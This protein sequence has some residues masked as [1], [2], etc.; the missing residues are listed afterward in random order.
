MKRKIFSLGRGFLSVAIVTGFL[1]GGL[2]DVKAAQPGPSFQGR[3]ITFVVPFTAGGGSDI[4][5]RMIARHLGQYL[6]GKP[7]IVI[8]NMP[9]AG[10]LIGGNHA[11]SSKANGLTC[12]ISSGG[13]ITA[14]IIRPKGIEYRLE[15]MY[16]LCSSPSGL[17]YYGKPNLIKEPKDIF[18]AKGLIFGHMPATGGTSSGFIWAKELLGFQTE[19]MI[20]A[21]GGSGDS[22][23][24]FLQGETNLCGESVSGYTT[25]MKSY[26]EKGQAVPI[27]QTGILDENGNV[28]RDPGA[29]DVLTAVEL[30]EQVH[31]KK[32]SGPDWKVYR[33]VVGGRTFDNSLLL[34]PKIPKDIVDLYGEAIPKMLKDSKFIAEAD[35]ITP[36][37]PYS[38]GKTLVKIFQE[39]VAAPP[40]VAEYMKR[41]LKEKYQVVLE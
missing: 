22:R 2:A 41:V 33:L 39:G 19:K 1:L 37:A 18:T 26:V 20:L 13:L 6:P 10:N 31:G 11:W 28:M 8:R 35:K 4:W 38:Y 16:P 24:A 5:G 34:P 12:L 7:N 14:N 15:E 40:D 30:Y 32:P 3:V 23:M 21:Y 29:P 36:K 17:I 25:A 9:G 27:F